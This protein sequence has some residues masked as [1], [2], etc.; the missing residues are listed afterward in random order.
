MPEKSPFAE[1]NLGMQRYQIR[2]YMKR[3]IGGILNAK[4]S[5]D[6][7]RWR[8]PSKNTVI[9]N[10]ALEEQRYLLQKKIAH[11]NLI[12]SQHIH[13]IKTENR[14][15]TTIEYA[16][17]WRIAKGGGNTRPV[18]DC[19]PTQRRIALNFHNL[20]SRKHI[21]EKNKKLRAYQDE[22]MAKN[23][24]SYK[25]EYNN[26]SLK[27]SYDKKKFLMTNMTSKIPRTVLHIGLKTEALRA[28]KREKM[29]AAGLRPP[30]LKHDA[31]NTPTSKKTL[32]LPKW[33]DSPV[34]NRKDLQELVDVSHPIYPSSVELLGPLYA[35]IDLTKINKVPTSTI[36]L[37]SS[38]KLDRDIPTLP[39]SQSI[40][41]PL[42]AGNIRP[43]TKH[44][45]TE[46]DKKIDNIRPKSANVIKVDKNIRNI[47]G[48]TI[49]DDWNLYEK[50]PLK[51]VSKVQ[52]FNDN[53]ELIIPDK[54]ILSEKD[55]AEEDIEGTDEDIDAFDQYLFDR[56]MA[57]IGEDSSNELIATE[58]E[59]VDMESSN[60]VL[61]TKQILDTNENIDIDQEPSFLEQ[62]NARKIIICES[63]IP[64]CAILNG[65]NEIPICRY[66]IR[67]LDVGLIKDI[68]DPKSRK[69]KKVSTTMG[70]LIEA[71]P[72]IENDE[73]R[74]NVHSHCLPNKTD[75]SS[76]N[77][78][79]TIQNEV[80]EQII[81]EENDVDENSS[82]LS[83]N[84]LIRI[85]ALKA[86]CMATRNRNLVRALNNLKEISNEDGYYVC[87]SDHLDPPSEESL[88]GLLL[89][90]IGIEL[91]PLQQNDGD[92]DNNIYD[93]I[94]SARISLNP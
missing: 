37:S 36:K 84:V 93:T 6:T 28:I 52:M 45:E 65:D 69:V 67:I 33:N 38:L 83:C 2:Y 22:R 16:N 62:P 44:E 25:S 27:K 68:E 9:V 78:I 7:S 50:I 66:I 82:Y 87:L 5:E 90:S 12:L 81:K 47:N 20:H 71:S 32:E 10:I 14:K 42:S 23:I 57:V 4:P 53:V 61:D 18:I 59:V 89:S 30:P 35:P 54:E 88:C 1:G 43:I 49:S 34:V 15:E 56:Y 39:Q 11:E 70:L 75:S 24:Q 91:H 76:K 63:A 48:T 21:D 80:K 64:A 77:L 73:S 40:K 51:K 31:P 41:R 58:N 55:I 8:I 86:L 17:G 3:F 79:E 46:Q 29:L 19:Y 94:W 72:I 74:D 26:K 92:Y 13:D 60:I 85:P